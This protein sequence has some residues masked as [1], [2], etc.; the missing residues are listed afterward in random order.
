MKFFTLSLLIIIT[1][2]AFAELLKPNP[3][4]KPEEIILIQLSALKKN[5]YP[6]LNAGIDQTW[7]FA[8]PSNRLFTGPLEKFTTMM[9]SVSY[10]AMLEHK[11]HNIIPHKQNDNIASFFVDLEDQGGNKYRFTW[12]LEKVKNQGE[13]ENC[14]MTTSVSQ[15]MLLEKSV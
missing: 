5:N 8:H 7:E 1:D 13:F 9:Y 2:I 3:N 15:P 6:Y 12:I 10:S 14:W 11:E 4:L